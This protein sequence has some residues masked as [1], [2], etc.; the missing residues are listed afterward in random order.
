MDQ[1]LFLALAGAVCAV[2]VG[3]ITLAYK[4]P[5]FYLSYVLTKQER[6][7]FT[8][9][10]F[11]YAMWFGMALVRQYVLNKLELPKETLVLFETAYDD[12]FYWVLFWGTVGVIFFG[13]VIFMM[14]IA[15]AS[16]RNSA[17]KK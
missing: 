2:F 10:L 15:N 4:D 12:L 14:S 16:I 5:Q 8:L 13:G 17:N 1:T 7:S 3:L 6:V 11:C 9:G